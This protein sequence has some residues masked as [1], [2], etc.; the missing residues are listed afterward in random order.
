MV[1]IMALFE[2]HR[3]QLGINLRSFQLGTPSKLFQ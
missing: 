1:L 3:S 2:V